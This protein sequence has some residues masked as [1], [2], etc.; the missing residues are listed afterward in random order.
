MF[1]ASLVKVV[2][3]VMNLQALRGEA[4][5]K[6]SEWGAWHGPGSYWVGMV[7]SSGVH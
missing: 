7:G 6:G 2:R 1:A 3:G 4:F 5:V